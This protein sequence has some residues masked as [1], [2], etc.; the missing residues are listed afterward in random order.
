VLPSRCL[1]ALSWLAC[2]AVAIPQ[3]SDSRQADLDKSRALREL[4]HLLYPQQTSKQ[5]DDRVRDVE[6]L[7]VEAGEL[8]LPVLREALNHEKAAT[9]RHLALWGLAIIGGEKAK[10]L[11][12]EADGG[13]YALNTQEML[14]F[15]MGSTGTPDDIRFLIASLKKDHRVGGAAAYALGVLRAK[16]AAPA[17]RAIVNAPTQP[18]NYFQASTALRWIEEG[19]RTTSPGP[20]RDEKEKI[21]HAVMRHGLPD[22]DEKGR[23]QYEPERHVIWTFR[24]QTWQQSRGLPSFNPNDPTIR[25]DVRLAKDRERAICSVTLSRGLGSSVGYDYV[26]RKRGGDWGVTGVALTW[27]S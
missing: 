7:C 18:W 17:L 6:T 25:F 14:C 3:A 24:G 13:Q 15:C 27:M 5:R 8:A 2:C 23:P 4:R 12:E 19:P 11:I 9:R 26:L 20:G 1:I 21:I 16:E 22:E 10:A